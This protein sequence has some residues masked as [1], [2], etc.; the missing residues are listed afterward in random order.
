MIESASNYNRYFYNLG[1]YV[2]IIWK[3]LNLNSC[4]FID[5]LFE[6]RSDTVE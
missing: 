1:Y 5:Y 4:R 2:F 6:K 3:Y